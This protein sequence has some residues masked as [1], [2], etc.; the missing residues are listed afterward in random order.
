MLLHLLVLLVTPLVMPSTCSI[1]SLIGARPTNR[2]LVVARALPDTVL[3]PTDTA[4]FLERDRPSETQ[5][6][7]QV[8]VAQR[9]E[10]IRVFGDG[11]PIVPNSTF[12]VIP[13]GYAADCSYQAWEGSSRWVPPGDEV[14]FSLAPTRR[15][16]S[17]EPIVD[18]LGWHSPYPTG[19]FWKYEDRGQEIGPRAGWLTA[20]EYFELILELPTTDSALGRRE[21]REAVERAF[22]KSVRWQSTFPGSAILEAYRGRN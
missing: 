9:F 5:L 19:E 16:E 4:D 12:A 21:K 11:L 20:D 3:V 13:W 18:V 6:R 15:T 2:M 7:V 17:Q 14:L 10:A 1:G 22:G 8:P